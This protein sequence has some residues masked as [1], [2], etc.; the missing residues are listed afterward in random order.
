[1]IGTI[2]VC[3]ESLALDGVTDRSSNVPFGTRDRV[4]VHRMFH[5]S[6]R[7]SADFVGQVTIFRSFLRL[8][9]A[10]RRLAVHTTMWNE[11]IYPELVVGGCITFSWFGVLVISQLVGY[12]F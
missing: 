6:V 9:E 3:V 7:S 1:M 11:K 2:D 8:K 5:H 10:I 12:R 4:L